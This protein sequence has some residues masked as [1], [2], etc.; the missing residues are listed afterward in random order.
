[1]LHGRKSHYILVK[2][3]SLRKNPVGAFGESG[4]CFSLQLVLIAAKLTLEDNKLLIQMQISFTKISLS[5]TRQTALNSNCLHHHHN[6][7]G[8]VKNYEK[9]KKC[10]SVYAPTNRCCHR[11]KSDFGSLTFRFLCFDD[12]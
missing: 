12:N 7:V 2:K 5:Q 4:A 10:K 9:G 11:E 3:Y 6:L 1:M 8:T